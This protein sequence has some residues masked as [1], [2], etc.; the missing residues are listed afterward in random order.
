MKET[1]EKILG[2]NGRMISGSKSGYMRNH[3]NNLTVF[4]SN[5]VI[6]EDNPVKIWYG[7]IDITLSIDDVKKLAKELDTTVYVLREMD[8]RFENE[9]RPR[10][11]RFVVKADANGDIEL[12]QLEVDYYSAENLMKINF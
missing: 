10:I 8:A 1:A 2:W 7:D 12:G 11:D 6:G 9:D 5:I 3:P 4:N